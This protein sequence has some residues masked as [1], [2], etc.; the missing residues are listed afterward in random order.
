MSW[1]QTDW[2]MCSKVGLSPLWPPIFHSIPDTISEL[3]KLTLKLLPTLPFCPSK[4]GWTS[5][6][7]SCSLE[8]HQLGNPYLIYGLP[9]ANVWAWVYDSPPPHPQPPSQGRY[10][11]V[12]REHV[13]SLTDPRLTLTALRRCC[14]IIKENWSTVKTCGTIHSFLFFSAVHLEIF[15]Q[16]LFILKLG[17]N[18]PP[19]CL[20]FISLPP[21]SCGSISEESRHPSLHLVPCC[22]WTFWDLGEFLALGRWLTMLGLKVTERVFWSMSE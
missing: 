22:I 16:W 20:L 19:K 13:G 6:K 5:R 10:G 14:R 9:V 4:P 3:W 8:P 2:L 18:V 7:K 12:K 1:E 21:C 15:D 11:R 17:T